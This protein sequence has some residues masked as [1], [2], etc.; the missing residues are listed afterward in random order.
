[1][2]EIIISKNPVDADRLGLQCINLTCDT[3]EELDRM[4]ATAR[5]MR[6]DRII[7]EYHEF[8]HR[9]HAVL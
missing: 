7:I 9:E 4:T 6:P 1:M 8:A 2:R 5:R 3:F